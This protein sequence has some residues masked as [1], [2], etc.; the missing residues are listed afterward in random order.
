MVLV[1]FSCFATVIVLNIH[2]KGADDRP[3]PDW[4]HR[5]LFRPLSK[6][7]CTREM[8]DQ[9]FPLTSHTSC[10]SLVRPSRLQIFVNVYTIKA[11]RNDTVYT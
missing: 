6:L 3:L 2:Y 7:M 1:G 8:T 4:A 5:L 10:A 11:S 9:E